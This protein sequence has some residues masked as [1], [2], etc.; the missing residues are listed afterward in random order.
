MPPTAATHYVRPNYSQL[1]KEMKRAGWSRKRRAAAWVGRNAVRGARAG[2]RTGYRHRSRLW[3]IIAASGMFA[4]SA[5]LSFAEDGWKTALVLS[6]IAGVVLGWNQYWAWRAFEEWMLRSLVV[7]WIVWAA[8]T[9]WTVT[10][11][12][13]SPFTTP[14]PGLLLTAALGLEAWWVI[15]RHIRDTQHAV[16]TVEEE[17]PNR[18]LDQRVEAW[19][20]NIACEGGAL[21]GSMLV[22]V[23]DLRDDEGMPTGRGWEALIQL[24]LT[25]AQNSES[26]VA[27]A[28]RIAKVY[29][30]PASQVVVEPP[31][32]GMED[33]ARLLVLTDNPLMKPRTFEGPTLNDTTGEF[34]IGVHAD[35]TSAL[36]RLWT[37]GSGV[38]HGMVAGTTGAGKSGLLMNLCAEIRHSGRA[39]LLLADPEGGESVRDWQLG[40]HCFAGT[41]PRIR[42]MLQGAERIMNARK[43]RRS[44]ETWVDEHGRTRRGR[45][46]FTPTPEDPA[47]Y[48]VIDEAPDVLADPECRRII[49][50][51]GKK[52]RKHGVAVIIFV[53][54]PS[55]S[56]LGG[57]LAVR[58]MLSSTNIVIFRT[59]DSLS[60]QMG[61]PM[62][63]PIDPAS[64]PAVFPD[65]SSTA[66]LG[67][68][69]SA[70]GRV[71]PMRAAWQEDPYV[72]ATT[73][74]PAPIPA[75]D[76]AAMADEQGNLFDNWR[77]LLDVDE[78]DEAEARETIAANLADSGVQVPPKTNERILAFLVAR[79]SLGQQA[80]RLGVIA[81]KLDLSK[82]AVSMAVKRMCAKTPPLVKDMGHGLWGLS[83]HVDVVDGELVGTAA[84]VA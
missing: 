19:M 65:G 30:V 78:D 48:C 68:R 47:V 57:D 25:D 31:L 8:A 77:E 11:S 28:R 83:E 53:Q 36:W 61:V 75:A 67:Y 58:S 15:H 27:A 73:G 55:L 69:A 66:G 42:R 1:R 80:V 50:A 62:Q 34:E 70:G 6:V 52:G 56:E 29:R 59:S 72:W 24:P 21:P 18:I 64:L 3:P 32:D 82:P 54:I 37:P 5:G 44:K 40:A 35:R 63:L 16:E 20:T 26:A 41:L 45:G 79:R 39:L 12:A 33:V 14:M 49:A 76:H 38:N 60:A 71:S 4:A 74:D 17:L 9:T 46:Y 22:G 7:S 51:I 10:A 13:I 23:D 2:I 43:R 81:D 84:G